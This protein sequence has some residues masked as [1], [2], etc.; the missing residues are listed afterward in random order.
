MTQT[1]TVSVI[2]P[3]YNVE[4]YLEECLD[5]ILS[6]TL[7]NIEVICVNDG[8]TDS[9][10]EIIQ[11]Y[12]KE[13]S[14][15]AIIDKPNAGYGHSV[16]QGL[17]RATGEWISIIEPDDWIGERMYEHLVEEAHL[18]DGTTPDIV[19]SSYWLYFDLEGSDPYVVR[20]NLM[21]C[22]SGWRH[23]FDPRKN[24]EVLKH[25]P[26]I[27]SAIYRRAFIEE[28]NIRMIEPKGAGWAD[29]PWFFETIL[30]A[31]RIVWV[32]CAYYRYRQTNPNASSKMA[33]FRMPFERLRDIRG[34]LDRL[35]M[36]SDRLLLAV[37]LRSFNYICDSILEEFG[38]PESDPELQALI[39]E[40]F[41]WMDPKLVLRANNGLSQAKKDYYRDFMG[42]KMA[43]VKEVSASSTPL[44]T[45]VL[46]MKDDRRGLWQT[47]DSLRRQTFTDFEVL[48][49]NCVSSDRSAE[50]A[51]GLSQRD[52]RFRFIE[53][54]TGNIG[55]GFNTGIVNA[56]GRWV[57][58][59][60]AGVE[61]GSKAVFARIAEAVAQPEANGVEAVLLRRDLQKY[62]LK[63]VT[64]TTGGDKNESVKWGVVNSDGIEGEIALGVDLAVYPKVFNWNFLADKGILFLPEGDNSGFAFSVRA[65]SQVRKVA[66]VFKAQAFGGNRE[67]L[68]RRFIKEE[69]DLIAHEKVKFEAMAKAA[70][71][72]GTPTAV[73]VGRVSILRAMGYS[74]HLKGLAHSG[75]AYYEMLK[76]VFEDGLGL[77]LDSY[78]GYQGDRLSLQ[79]AFETTYEQYTKGENAARRA[80]AESAAQGRGALACELDRTKSSRSYQLATSISKGAK[81][82]RKV[83]KR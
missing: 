4:D 12:E 64:T 69:E 44:I 26:S 43:K 39:R 67:R 80:R 38:F 22:M 31:N 16:N 74:L 53:E 24:F 8:S 72:V 25:H 79:C 46:P 62:V 66:F 3:I 15:V 19:K 21:N 58:F 33:D 83:I 47:V 55:C 2:V 17:E 50:I 51:Q 32:P 63:T 57:M 76:E 45:V 5:S 13:D 65:M 48:L 52:K 73:I 10:L 35:D 61:L 36:H 30:Q 59:L 70:L 75:K 6:Q 77:N 78:E 40:V 37:Y 41:E 27:W 9:S 29:N 34:V 56:N 42:L 28:K 81:K 60:R 23:E 82:V 54:Q 18:A 20:P 11:R 68:E 7:Q 49:I 14:R 71:E 1:P